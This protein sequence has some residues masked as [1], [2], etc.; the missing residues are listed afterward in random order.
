MKKKSDCRR[1]QFVNAALVPLLATIRMQQAVVLHYEVNSDFN[2]KSVCFLFQAINY[3]DFI[4]IF[5]FLSFS[6][7]LKCLG[8]TH[9]LVGSTNQRA[10]FK[11]RFT[12]GPM[13]RFGWSFTTEPDSTQG[14]AEG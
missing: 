14:T 7:V 1:R 5:N 10:A 11:T 8:S 4:L 3:D 9:W 12:D 13:A 6:A 2:Y